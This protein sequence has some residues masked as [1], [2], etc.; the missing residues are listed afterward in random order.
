M[1]IITGISGIKKYRRAVVALGVFDGMHLG[2]RH[3]LTQAVRKARRISGRSVVVTFYP[4][5][6]NQESLYSLEHRIKLIAELGIDVCIVLGFNRKFSRISAEDFVEHILFEK[7]RVAHV[8]VGK[9]FRFGRGAKGDFRLLQSLSRTYNFRLRAFDV[10]KRNR[11]AVSSTQVRRLIAGG[12]LALASSLLC[13][14][15]NVFGTVTKGMALGRKL[16]FPTANI[17][18]HHEVLPPAGVYAVTVVYNQKKFKGV[19]Y[20]GSKATFARDSKIYPQARRNPQETR[21]VEVHIFNFKQNIYGRN[22]EIQFVRRLR[23]D[24]K[25]NSPAALIGQIKKDILRAKRI[26]SPL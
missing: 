4:H 8:Y 19:C 12:R 9:N 25:F 3:I 15:V 2:H 24:K 20:I 21:S 10:I 23:K 18:P 16:G 14:P 13:R 26:L 7:I 17:N 5:P 6:Q 1:E 11:K 22:L